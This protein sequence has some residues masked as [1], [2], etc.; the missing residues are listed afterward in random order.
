MYRNN[1]DK[2]YDNSEYYKFNVYDVLDN[3]IIR[4]FD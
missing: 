2:I 3:T 1:F 4:A